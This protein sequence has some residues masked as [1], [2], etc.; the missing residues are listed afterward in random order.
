M[1][2]DED[3]SRGGEGKRESDSNE[4]RTEEEETREYGWNELCEAEHEILTLLRDI[5]KL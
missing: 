2:I 4:N 1:I 5:L 3:K